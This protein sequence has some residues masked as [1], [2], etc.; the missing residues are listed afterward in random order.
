MQIWHGAR[1]SVIIMISYLPCI[2]VDVEAYE[3]IQNHGVVYS[4]IEE[5]LISQLLSIQ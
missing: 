3:M 2:K 1:L 5:R 4:M